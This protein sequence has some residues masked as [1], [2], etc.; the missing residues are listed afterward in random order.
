MRTHF[1]RVAFSVFFFSFACMLSAN[2]LLQDQHHVSG[3]AFS[4]KT[5]KEHSLLF[6]NNT[7]SKIKNVRILAWKQHEA[8]PDRAP[9]DK[10][11]EKNALW[12]FIFSVV[13]VLII[14]GTFLLPA[15]AVVEGVV[16]CGTPALA[17]LSFGVFLIFL[18]FLLGI[19]ALKKMSKRPKTFNNMWQAIISIAIGTA[20]SVLFGRVFLMVV[21]LTTLLALAL[22]N[23]AGAKKK[24]PVRKPVMR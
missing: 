6:P 11:M 7:A 9:K 18:G 3:Y 4:G 13:G 10:R 8:R 5:T 20:L 23:N 2:M 1:L 24:R 17:G 14:V 19:I 12:G 21:A 15:V 22:T 16:E